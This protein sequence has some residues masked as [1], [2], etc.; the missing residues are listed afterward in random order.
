MNFIL[1]MRVRHLEVTGR[2]RRS[3]DSARSERRSSFSKLPN[4]FQGE[5]DIS[6]LRRQTVDFAVGY[7]RAGLIKDPGAVDWLRRSKVGVIQN[8][9]NL[10]AE[11]NIERFRKAMDRNVL[12]NGEIQIY[13]FWT[14]D[15]VAARVSQQIRA[16]YSPAR[17]RARSA[18]E[19]STLCGK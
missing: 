17:R 13:K 10:C 3:V 9:E 6:W 8:I 2:R 4:Q 16:I 7:D 12:D 5:L 11:L 1:L 14:N 19:I 15:G 18:R